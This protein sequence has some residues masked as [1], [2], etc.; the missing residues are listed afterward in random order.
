MSW[1]RNGL[2]VGFLELELMVKV[3]LL[4]RYLIVRVSWLSQ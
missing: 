3:Y 2:L 4:Q 1:K